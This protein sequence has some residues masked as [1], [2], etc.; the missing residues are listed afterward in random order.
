MR[1]KT[2]LAVSAL[3][4]VVLAAAVLGLSSDVSDAASEKW[5]SSEC[6][7]LSVSY[8]DGNTYIV[9]ELDSDPGLG[10]YNVIVGGKQYA[11]SGSDGKRVGIEMG[12]P[13]DRSVN[14]MI[15]ATPNGSTLTCILSYVQFVDV[16]AAAS[17]AAGGTVSGAGEVRSG[18]QVTLTATASEYYVFDG[19][20]VGGSKVSAV[21]EY[22]FTATADTDCTAK[23]LQKE[24]SVV[25]AVDG[26]EVYRDTVGYGDQAD[27]RERY[28]KSGYTVTDWESQDVTVVDGKFTMPD[29]DV[30]FTAASYANKRTVTFDSNGGSRVDS[31]MQ[32]VGTALTAPADPVREGYAFSGW[33]PALPAVMP[34]E[35]LTVVAQWAINSYSIVFDTDGGSRVD[36]MSVPYGSAVTAPSAPT[37]NGYLFSG[38]SPA[39][40]GTMPAND[41][42]VKAVWTKTDEKKETVVELKDSD[43]FVMPALEGKPVVVKMEDNVSVKVENPSGLTGKTIVSKVEEVPVT[44]QVEGTAKAYEFTFTADEQQYNGKMLVTLPYNPEKGKTPAV[45]W[46]NGSDLESMRIVSK[47][48]DSVTFETAHN[49]TYVV[50]AEPYPDDSEGRTFMLYFGILTVASIALALL[51]GGI[52]YRGKA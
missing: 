4:A 18:T 45:Y 37:R 34:A 28:V 2:V 1:Y 8:T 33:D 23:F 10:M 17:P 11:A 16:T 49:S 35:D 14:Y 26:V 22:A 3:F 24:H 19:W 9:I 47:T 38:W 41:L 15:V 20:Y 43:T 52:Y 44:A 30:T 13:L 39:L 46:Q 48:S 31:I 51:A 42:T 40:P 29:R 25:Y 12:T 27:V 32:D 5:I 50:V 21:A 36:S 7:G 6:N